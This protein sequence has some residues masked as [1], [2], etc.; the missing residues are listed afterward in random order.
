MI[1]KKQQSTIKRVLSPFLPE[2]IGVFG[3][4]ARGEQGPDSDLDLLVKFGKRL[5]LLDLVGLELDL[6]DELGIKVD[7]VTVG[8]LSPLIREYVEKDLKKIA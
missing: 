2:Y 3:S 4:F 5:S 7:L 6:T 8:G 1:T